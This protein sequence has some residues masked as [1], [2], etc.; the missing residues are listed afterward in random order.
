LPATNFKALHVEPLPAIADEVQHLK[1]KRL[2]GE[3][4]CHKPKIILRMIRVKYL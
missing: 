2:R 4:R 3:N 1:T